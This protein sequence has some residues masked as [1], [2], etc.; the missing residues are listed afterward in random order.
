MVELVVASGKGGT[1]KTSLVG[2]FAALAGKTVL[3]D[4]DVD[5]ANLNLIIDHDIIEKHDFSSS[6]KASIVKSRCSSCGICSEK[7]RFEAIEIDGEGVYSIDRLSCEGC[8]LCKELCPEDAIEFEPVISGEHYDSDSAF[9]PFFHA[10]LGIAEANS[11]KLVSVLKKK[12]HE[13]AVESNF[14]LILVDGPPGIGC[15]VIASLTGATYLLIVTEPSLSAMHDMKRL[16]ELA[17]HF[18]IRVGLCIN[19][20]DINT[21]LSQRIEEYAAD[22]RIGF[23]GKIPFDKV[24]TEAQI[25]GKPY[26]T[27]ASENN[28]M[29]IETIWRSVHARLMTISDA[30]TSKKA[31]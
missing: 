24:F 20:F 2:S 11:G 4:C 17:S 1:G 8:G 15:P 18:K 25:Q 31:I 14:D 13:K 9:G 22:N 19:K 7:C 27:E 28:R 10:K 30:Q 29:N 23:H 3:V 6:K 21:E 5:A 26:I 12:A 16:V